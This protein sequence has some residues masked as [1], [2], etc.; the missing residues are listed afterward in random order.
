MNN[1]RIVLNNQISELQAENVRLTRTNDAFVR[2]LKTTHEY[3]VEV[4]DVVKLLNTTITAAK[5]DCN[6]V[7]QSLAEQEELRKEKQEE[8]VQESGTG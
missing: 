8:G 1:E 7:L 6:N 4:L 5:E 3:Y 2:L